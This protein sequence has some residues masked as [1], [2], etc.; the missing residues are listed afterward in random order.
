MD[1]ELLMIYF[2]S[3]DEMSIATMLQMENLFGKGL[4]FGFG[5]R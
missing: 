1:K 3:I 4:R 2:T 5:A